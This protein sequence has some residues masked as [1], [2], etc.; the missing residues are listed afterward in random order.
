[1]VSGDLD[2]NGTDDLVV[3]FGVGIGVY[4]WMNPTT[5]TFIHPLSPSRMVAGDLDYDGRAEIVLS[6]RVRCVVLEQG[7][8]VPT[9]SVG[10]H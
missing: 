4:A 2:F 8:L 7:K 5:W 3:N 1:M 6:S 10:R 9:A